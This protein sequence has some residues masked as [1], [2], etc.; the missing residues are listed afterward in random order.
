MTDKLFIPK[1]ISVGYQ[2]RSDTY[3]DLL[4]YVIYTDDKGV[5]R[6]EGSWQSWRDSNID[7]KVF[8]NEPT[9]GFILNKGIGG[10]GRGW[11]SRQSKIRIYDPRG[12]EIE[13]T[14]ANLLFI[15]QEYT[16]AIGKEFYGKFVQA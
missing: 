16:S 8:N 2:K 14:V 15:L 12:H 5:L 3:S 9:E 13:I 11:D 1:T 10:G 4:G 6:K 7:P